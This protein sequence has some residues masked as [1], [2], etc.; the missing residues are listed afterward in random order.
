MLLASENQDSPLADVITHFQ[1]SALL[2]PPQLE[3]RFAEYT[4]NNFT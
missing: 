4:V 3:K 1:H 2:L